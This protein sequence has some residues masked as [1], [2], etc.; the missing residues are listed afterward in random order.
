MGLVIEGEP[1][2]KNLFFQKSE[3][4]NPKITV[5]SKGLFPFISTLLLHT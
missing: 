3:E 1:K 2:K 4:K 5:F